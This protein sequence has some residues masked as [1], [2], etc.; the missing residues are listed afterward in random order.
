LPSV[1][2]NSTEPLADVSGVDGA[3]RLRLLLP[4]NTGTAACASKE[5]HWVHQFWVFEEGSLAARLLIVVLITLG[6]G[7]TVWYQGRVW[8]NGLRFWHGALLGLGGGV[9]VAFVA[10][11]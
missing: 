4:P 8:K 7:A 3:Q 10:I 6:A 5:R 2:Q 9:I 1:S 11:D